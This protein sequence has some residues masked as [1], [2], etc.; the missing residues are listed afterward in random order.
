MS[1]LR[2]IIFN[3][4]FFIVLFLN[5]CIVCIISTINQNYGFAVWKWSSRILHLICKYIVNIDFEIVNPDNLP[6]RNQALCVFGDKK[7]ISFPNKINDPDDKACIFA[8][9]HESTW[10]TLILI[11]LFFRPVFVL[12]KQLIDVPFFGYMCS[13]L[14]MIAVDRDDGVKS[15]VQSSLSVKKMIESGHDV[16]IFP[17]GTR[18]KNGEFVPLKRGISLFYKKCNVDVIP[19]ILNSGKFWPRRSF[20]KKSGTI[21]VKVLKPIA[22]GYSADEFFS[23]LEKCFEVEIKQMNSQEINYEKDRCGVC[24]V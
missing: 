19:I 24:D 3:F 10:E 6:A 16:V 18:V 11:H 7:N 12:K 2:S 17:E 23:T 14:G 1:F 13:K 8:V 15:L 22:P 9:R 5:I 20:K 4:I 21:T